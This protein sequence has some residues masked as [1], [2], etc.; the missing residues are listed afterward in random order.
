[1]LTSN[2]SP[3]PAN[4]SGQTLTLTG[5]S[6]AS[7][8][9][10][11]VSLNA[12]SITYS[13]AA[14]FNGSD[15]FTYTVIDNGTTHGQPDPKSA[16]GTV[17]VTVTPVNQPPIVTAYFRATAE[18]APLSIAISD[19]LTNDSPGPANESAQTISLTNVATNSSSGGSVAI[20]GPNV[21]YTPPN[22]F[23]GGD[24]FNYTIADNG[25]TSGSPDFKSTVGT[26]FVTV[27][28]VNH[29]PIAVNDSIAATLNTP[30]NFAATV[31]TA[32]DL[33][34]PA[35][36]SNQTLTVTA[37]SAASTQGGTV[38]LSNGTITY[39]PANNFLGTDTFTY[40]VTDNGTTGGSQA[41][42][43]A[44]GTV[45][46]TVSDPSGNQP[47][48]AGSDSIATSENT[49]KTVTTAS[50]LSNDAPGPISESAQTLS[51]TSVAVTS[52]R[53]GTA[54]L[55]GA[56]V[57]YTPP[58]N[59]SG[60]DSFTY[61]ITDNGTP[62]MS[63]S[64]TVFVT[65]S[66][67]NAAPT[68]N[69]DSFTTAEDTPLVVAASILTSNDSPGPANESTQTL[70]VTSVS[71]Q[72]S[73]GGTV[74]LNAG[75]LT[76]TP[77]ASFNGAD[78]F[79][80]IVTDDGTTNSASDPKTAIG[81]VTV[82]VTEVNQPPVAGTVNLSTHENVALS[83]STATLLAQDSPGPANEST[84]TLTVT[85]VSSTSTAGGTV[86]LNGTQIVYTPPTF[87]YGDDSFNYTI[88]DNGTTHGEPDFK[89]ATGVVNI[90]VLPINQ[91]PTA[92]A[93]SLR[94]A[95]DTPLTIDVSVLLANDSPG[96]ANEASQ[97]L[98]ITGIDGV[99]QRFGSV[100]LINGSITY[101]P[102]PDYFG[103][104]TFTYT[105]TDNGVSVAHS[106]PRSAV[107]IVT[108]T[109]TAVNDPPVVVKATFSGVKDQQLAIATSAILATAT[110]GPENE[111]DQH[112]A[113]TSVDAVTANN[114]SAT[115]TGSTILYQPP[116]GFIGT[117]TFNY[118]ITDDGVT[119]GTPDPRSASASITVLVGAVNQP[120]VAANDTL[121]AFSGESATVTVATL[122]ANDQPGPPSE[123]Q[124]Q[125]L[126]LTAVSPTSV[127]GGTVTLTNGS[128]T[129]VSPSQYSGPDSF[130]YPRSATTARLADCPI[131]K[132]RV[133]RCS[134]A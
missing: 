20:N 55:N 67:V 13:P 65:V 128:V 14:N 86:A 34:G 80:Y 52:A 78:S 83:I 11:T 23:F 26:V 88:T 101:T 53:G 130:T 4:E 75:T 69:P 63:A 21:I 76:Y 77:P 8:H 58:Q 22:T 48:V 45:T 90:S 61:T 25:T 112:L 59:F 50:L 129:Y 87:F 117:D 40:T 114:G 125:Q 27:T 62:P 72:S 98:T 102:A 96:P 56:N 15:S 43:S 33:P 97:T 64:G 1:M 120:P 95:E 42:K 108:V 103:D 19:I 46:V 115:L 16:T 79:T 133:P 119:D 113:L 100:T 35:N 127:Q 109:V 121:A 28:A 57:T 17:T 60:S 99:T 85:S 32:N 106:D 37:V 123:N 104:D 116:P 10:G 131:R 132:R 51:L 84:Q 6:P 118:T 5:V 2:D 110:P 7:A 93:D 126:T 68:A 29:P 91:P 12:G 49:P 38:A 47:P 39:T 122:L 41:P 134:S 24:S 71:A 18:D 94:T 44:D 92:V 82:T 30:K 31:L 54:A 9:G 74:A 124:Q 73:Q 81:T 66:E 89:S 107:G 3:G 36:E 111:S 105:I 70:T